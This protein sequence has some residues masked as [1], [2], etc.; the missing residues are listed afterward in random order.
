M[1]HFNLF[2]KQCYHIVQSV[3]KKQK[4]KTQRFQRQKKKKHLFYENVQY[5]IV[6]KMKFIKE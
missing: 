1:K 4:L 3:E 6:K 5:G 2:I